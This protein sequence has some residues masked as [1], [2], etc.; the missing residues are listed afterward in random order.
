MYPLFAVAGA[1][2][3]LVASI[4][5]CPLDVV[6]TKL[7]AQTLA[8][9]HADYLG[10]L[11]TYSSFELVPGEFSLFSKQTPSRQ[12]SDGMVSAAFIAALVQPFLAIFLP[13]PFIFLSTMAL[14]H[15]LE[16][17][18]SAVSVLRVMSTLRPNPRVI[19]QRCEIIHGP[20]T[21]YQQ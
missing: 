7:Q 2:G 11:G 16:R 9:G 5:T 4:A 20:F 19:S 6:K 1:G 10:V 12:F 18:R 8:R 17:L 14:R 15:A 21:F 3:G 13:G